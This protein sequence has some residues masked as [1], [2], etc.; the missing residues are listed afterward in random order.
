MLTLAPAFLAPAFYASAFHTSARR[1][2]KRRDKGDMAGARELLMSDLLQFSSRRW[3]PQSPMSI[4]Y[5]PF[6]TYPRPPSQISPRS[7]C[8]S[9]RS[10]TATYPPTDPA[11]DPPMRPPHREMAT[12]SHP[13]HP[14]RYEVIVVFDAPGGGESSAECTPNPHA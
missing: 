5:S 13:H 4:A 11:P 7:P 10:A 6:Y 2:K 3:D 14:R 12:R 9:Q 8:A 1:L